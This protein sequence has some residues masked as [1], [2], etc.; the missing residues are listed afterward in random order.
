MA[1]E[2]SPRAAGVTVARVLRPH[3]RRGEVAAEIL[4]DF[5][6]HLT[7]LAFVELWDVRPFAA[8]HEPRRVAVRS[9]RLTQSRGGQ[10]I[11]HF[12]GS[13]SIS[14]AE[15]LVG[16]EVRIPFAERMPLPSGSYYVTDLI[17]CEVRE[18][19]GAAIGRVRDVQATGEDVAGTP[20][21]VIDSP[22]G[23]LLIPLAQEICVRVDVDA[24]RIEVIL[25]EGLRELNRDS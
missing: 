25:P 20:V 2:Q 22:Q 6:E 4:T 3:G 15:R 11:F 19:G 9:C 13:D 21:L 1:T 14:D 24:R 5:P 23:E 10:A 7:R 18:R 12:E 16:L 17:G 8:A